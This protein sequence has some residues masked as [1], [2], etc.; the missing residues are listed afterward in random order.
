MRLH[1][2]IKAVVFDLDGTLLESMEEII[3]HLNPV[4]VAHGAP[5]VT[6]SVFREAFFSPFEN[7][8]K[9]HGP[10][11]PFEKVIDAWERMYDSRTCAF[12]PGAADSVRALAA[13]GIPLGIVSGSEMDTVE[14]HAEVNGITSC[15]RYMHGGDGRK[16]PRMQR[17]C[18]ITGS[19]PEHTAYVGDTAFDM[20]EARIAGLIP[21]GIT[22]GCEE[23][24]VILQDAGAVYVIDHLRELVELVAP[25][26]APVL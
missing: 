13:R 18:D 2:Q 23:A 19:A 7:W 24:H 1:E 15:F 14:Y 20:H 6:Y 16:V 5:G 4:F 9:A 12:Y 11:V 10:Q 25:Q 21:V 8:C 22:W 26:H 3:R 17:F